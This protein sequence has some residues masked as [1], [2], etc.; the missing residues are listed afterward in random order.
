ME[1]PFLFWVK[2][3]YSFKWGIE[4][5]E[6][7]VEE[8]RRCGFG[9][10][11]LADTAGLYGQHRFALAAVKA[12]IKGAAGA[13]IETVAG[14]MV[15]GALSAGWSQLCRLITSAH[16]PLRADPLEAFSDSSNL[17]IIAKDSLQ[18]VSVIER[19]WKGRVYI[20][21]LPGQPDPECPGGVLPLAC[22]PSM[23]VG[24]NSPQVHGM[25]R[26]FDELLPSPHVN[27]RPIC[28]CT[29]NI[30][31][32]SGRLWQS[33]PFALRNNFRL[34]ELVSTL[35]V[36]SSYRP[37]VITD[38]DTGRLREILFPRLTEAYGSSEAAEKRLIEEL[39]EL[40]VAGLCG[41]FLVFHRV[42]SYCREQGIVAIAR[43]SAAGSLVSRLLGLSAIC[44]IRY[45]LSFSRFFNRLRDDPPD[46]DLDIDGSRRDEVYRWFLNEWGERTAAVSATVTYRT[47]SAVRVAA[48]ACG[49]SRDETDVLAELSRNLW[50]P[51]WKQPLPARVMEQAKLLEGLPSHL[52]P[53]PC[54]VV[55]GD[56]LITSA[57]PVEMCS[58]GLPV[59]Q[60]DMHG[61]EYTGLIKMD[62]L[63]QRGLTSLS[64]ASLSADPVKLVNQN[65]FIQGETLCLINEGRTI[66]VP[67]IE[68]PAMRGLLKRMSIR[69]VEDVA[70]ALALV[71]PG[72]ASGGGRDKYMAGGERNIPVVLRN[73][74]RENRGVMLYQENVTE[75]A[76]ALL[77]LSPAEGDQ[78]RRRLK[79]RAVEK[80]EII[81]LC[82]ANGFSMEIA[83]RGWELLSGYAGYG[84]CKAHAMT[85]AAVASAYASIKAEKPATAMAA[86]LAAGGGFYRHPVYIEEARRLGLKILPPDVNTSEW[87]CTSPDEK[88]LMVGMG[89]L[90]GMGET[91]FEKLRKGRPYTHPVQV[92]A[93]GIGMKL[94][95]NMAMA[96]C[97]DFL[98][99]NRPQASWCVGEMVSTLF[100]FGMPPPFLPSYIPSVRAL[101]ELELMEVTTEAHP[102]AFRERPS[103]TVPIASMQKRGISAIWGRVLTG[104]SL[105]GEAGFFMMEDETGVADVFVP[106]PWYRKASVILRRPRATLVLL[107]ET[108][109]ERTVVRNVID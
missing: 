95:L 6:T 49:L 98:G 45:G 3:A 66:G 43:G 22:F 11:M 74:L 94:A 61:V 64:L 20:P 81:S 62:L 83:E 67:H 59:T 93:A 76:C 55:V 41:Y 13:E 54:G 28:R 36:Q 46:I 87:F 33:A 103:G 25:L 63:G 9:G 75:A 96:G 40:S 8:A 92:R 104:R 35:P 21:V 26:R 53:H 52:M 57:V 91:E 79:R 69:S 15:V 29:E 107:C 5:P 89:Y 71:R 56:G 27:K 14:N 51:L 100:P 30:P 47:K 10:V 90:A 85:Y 86:F 37:P 99:M 32:Y 80:H 77:G 78:M 16:L 84:F 23:F 48:A 106:S 42:I 2:S 88:S 97:F 1:K 108:T 109:A 4:L 73:I 105:K 58:G 60:L 31:L 82:V 18:G 7:L 34:G 12:G 24:Q 17:F 102:L 101:K 19:G 65:G 70:R 68:S 44:P 39:R 72:A 50:N 38:D